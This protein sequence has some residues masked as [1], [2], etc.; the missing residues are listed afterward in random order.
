MAPVHF[1]TRGAHR[2][3]ERF[4]RHM[5]HPVRS[6]PEQGGSHCLLPPR[7]GKQWDEEQGKQRSRVKR[8]NE[9]EAAPISKKGNWLK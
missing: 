8:R 5:V 2:L 7:M 4:H 1:P 6:V 3:R 9:R